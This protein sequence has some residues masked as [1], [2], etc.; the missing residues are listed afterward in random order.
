MV[1]KATVPKQSSKQSL[2]K[3]SLEAA[4]R[5]CSSKFCNNK[6]PVLE[7]LFNNVKEKALAQVFSCEYRKIFKNSFRYRTPLVAAF[8]SLI[9]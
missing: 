4:V 7:S 3:A 6:T 5:I 2:S 8:V 1:L 9:K